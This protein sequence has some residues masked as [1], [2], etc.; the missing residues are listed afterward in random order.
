M[1]LCTLSER[2]SDV[3]I[4]IFWVRE[5]LRVK[6]RTV[7]LYLVCKHCTWSFAKKP[8]ITPLIG[9]RIT[10]TANPAM[11]DG[12]ITF[13]NRYKAIAMV[14]GHAHNSYNGVTC[15]W[16]QSGCCS[17]TKKYVRNFTKS[18]T[19]FQPRPGAHWGQ[20]KP[21]W[22]APGWGRPVSENTD[23]SFIFPWRSHHNY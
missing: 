22:V 21:G 19:S 6:T 16:L 5:G 17:K 11:L 20:I 8:I 23:K 12:P 3:G 1:G 13:H 18:F 7:E 15:I 2:E 4:L 14:T 9:T 10:S